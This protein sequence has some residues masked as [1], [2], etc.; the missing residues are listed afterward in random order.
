MSLVAATSVE[1]RVSIFTLCADDVRAPQLSGDFTV[2]QASVTTSA[3]EADLQ[4]PKGKAYITMAAIGADVFVVFKL[5]TSAAT[6]TTTTGWKIPSG[7]E[8]SF[9]VESNVLSYFEHIGS[10]A[11]TVKWYV[12]STIR[13]RPYGR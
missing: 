8:R 3:A 13:E 2:R 4:L 5:G 9:F 10:G 6:V 12:S 1:V 7:E 11:G